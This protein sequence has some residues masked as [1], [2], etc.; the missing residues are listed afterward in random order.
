[1]LLVESEVEFQ[2][3]LDVKDQAISRNLSKWRMLFKKRELNQNGLKIQ[4]KVGG[5]R[6]LAYHFEKQACID[7]LQDL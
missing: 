2:C 6:K 3:T 1:M 5:Y 4:T 7:F